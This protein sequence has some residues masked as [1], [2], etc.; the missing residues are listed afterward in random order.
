MCLLFWVIFIKAQT[1]LND[2]LILYLPF[3]DENNDFSGYT[4]TV[5][6]NGNTYIL[7]DTMLNGQNAAHF[8]GT[9]EY[10]TVT[11]NDLLNNTGHNLTIS[12]WVLPYA[13]WSANDRAAIAGKGGWDNNTGW[14]LLVRGDLRIEFGV[15]YSYSSTNPIPINQW[16]LITA[17]FNDNLDSTWI[18]VNGVLQLAAYCSTQISNSPG[19]VYIGRR[20]SGN[21][22]I[23]YLNGLLSDVRVYNR[24]LS[25]T[26]VNTLYNQSTSTQHI[27]I[28]QNVHRPG[29]GSVTLTASGC[30]NY[31]WYN[32][33]NSNIPVSTT[34][35]YT[36]TIN[37]THTFYVSTYVNS[38]ESIRVPVIAEVL[39]LNSGLVAYY[40]FNS[41]ANDES[42][43]GNNG[44][45]MYTTLTTD[46]FGNANSAYYFD[47]T[48]SY[49]SVADN[50]SL[51][52]A[53]EITLAAWIKIDTGTN[54]NV[55]D[56]RHIISKGAIF[57]SAVPD[58]AIGLTNPDGKLG[59]DAQASASN[60]PGINAIPQNKW[61]FVT[62][63]YTDSIVKLFQNGQ[64]VALKRG[65]FNNLN[66]S[67][68]PLYIGCRYNSPNVVGQFKGNIDDVRIYNRALFDQE[69][70]ELYNPNGLI[71]NYQFDGNANDISG[72][73]NNGIVTNATLTIG[74]NG[75]SN[76]AYYFDGS[77]GSYIDAGD[78]FNSANNGQLAISAWINKEIAGSYAGIIGKWQSTPSSTNPNSFLLGLT[79]D[80]KANF[81]INLEDNTTLI[82]ISDCIIPLNKWIN[83]TG[84]FDNTTGTISIYVNGK[85]EGTSTNTN[86]IGK[87]I[88]Y[89]TSYTAKIGTW[90]YLHANS[91]YYFK[92]KIDDI[93]VFNRA[94]KPGELENLN[95]IIAHYSLNNNADD[96]T[97]NQFNG[98][99]HGS[100]GT[101]NRY[102]D[103]NTAMAFN[104]TDQYISIPDTVLANAS[105]FSFSGWIKTTENHRGSHHYDY[106]TILGIITPNNG[107]NDF[108]ISNYGGYIGMWSG[109][110][111]YSD[112][113]IISQKRINDNNWHHIVLT[114]NHSQLKLY[115][116]GIDINCVLPATTNITN[117]SP[118]L[119]ASHDYY[120]GT[121][122]PVLFHEGTLDDVLFYN[123]AIDTLDIATLYGNGCSAHRPTS[124]NVSRWGIGD[125]TLQAYNG[126]DY[127]W[128]DHAWS[129]NHLGDGWSYNTAICNQ[130]DTFYVANYSGGCESVRTPVIASIN[131][132]TNGLIAYYPFNN[133]ANDISGNN[134]NGTNN[135]ATPVNN[136]YGAV[137]SAYYFNGNNSIE[138]PNTSNYNLEQG[139][140]ISAWVNFK[141]LTDGVIA[142]K[143]DYGVENGFMLFARNN[144]VC[145][146]I[147]SEPPIYSPTTLNDSVW[148]HVVTTWDG[149]NQIF[150]VDG[151]KISEREWNYLNTNAFNFS[152]GSSADNNGYFNGIIDDVAFYNRP[153]T[154]AEIV[155]LG[156]I[157]T[158]NIA[159]KYFN[160][161]CDSSVVLT[162]FTTYDIDSAAW[163][164]HSLNPAWL[165]INGDTIG[166]GSATVSILIDANTG[167]RRTGK[168]LVFHSNT[169]D[170]ITVSQEA[171]VPI[172][173]V[174]TNTL[175]IGAT[176]NSH[177]SFNITSNLSWTITSNQT[178][179]TSNI[180]SGNGNATITLTAA[181]N[182]TNIPRTAIITIAGVGNVSQTITV[183]QDFIT[184]SFSDAA[185]GNIDVYPNPNNGKFIITTENFS[186]VEISIV[187]L[188][189]RVVYNNNVIEQ[190][191]IINVN[192]ENQQK[193]IYILK[194]K[195]QDKTYIQKI[196]IK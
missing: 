82:A 168:L 30:T 10:L 119:M 179:L 26:E 100:I 4:H 124:E 36:T 140:S 109:L 177:V 58:Y 176:A 104:G 75:N 52:I 62:I 110:N 51:H 108:G 135:G 56:Y 181:V 71:A 6:P 59:W 60:L 101:N 127:K 72:G 186:L 49:I 156:Q 5:S 116:D 194:L 39:S 114:Y 137:N 29:P 2:S 187:D 17:V 180:N 78:F 166:A 142:G 27:P 63:T 141:N 189:G 79:P 151:L 195:S 32:S 128:Y 15:P 90:G 165:H 85:L 83:I 88:K 122:N 16:S 99:N 145:G 153:L 188:M 89:H 42:G 175:S 106:P 18:Y 185:K 173:S 47:G 126:S 3:F 154:M 40:P 164:I 91:T 193:G 112:N 73:G 21:S 45:T 74:H 171:F 53:D 41:N 121:S 120:N 70:S 50:N 172:L 54:Y 133:N 44:T 183:T 76:S 144:K 98:I 12:G 163:R 190:S 167:A 148:H 81:H 118:W 67:G 31:R 146:Y 150:Y 158:I 117:V 11:G 160:V 159:P 20:A 178:W 77:T 174:S 170:T 134:L 23:G 7:N 68:Q 102:E 155:K 57:G 182:L 191:G 107:T 87:K 24:A 130:T 103:T 192:M 80:D 139:H 13:T 125:F 48:N 196:A 19:D 113:S 105:T 46:R 69:V 143:H 64:L 33:I 149:V 123:Y 111:P 94:L 169:S 147:S 138:I 84:T 38:F 86:A 66:I 129:G 22:Y 95:G 136:R 131:D 28:A 132:L 152:I 115:V 1:N 34:S 9:N 97:S 61:V 14:E 37:S 55:Y 25:H 65:S 96:I 162:N 161:N 157:P 43:K 8:N 184:S 93:K 92:G 35:S